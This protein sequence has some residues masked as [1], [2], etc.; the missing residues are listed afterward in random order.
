[1]E[2]GYQKTLEWISD[3]PI[4]IELELAIVVHGY[5]ELRIALERQTLQYCTA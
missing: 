1:M 4:Y 2:S 5:F 3:F